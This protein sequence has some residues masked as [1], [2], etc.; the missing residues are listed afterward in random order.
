MDKTGGLDRHNEL[1]ED[2]NLGCRKKGHVNLLNSLLS[3][4]SKFIIIGINL[5]YSFL[6]K[7]NKKV[8]IYFI[9]L[10]GCSINISMM[11]CFFS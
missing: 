7:N 5:Y 3:L 11:L 8:K 1:R 4:N 10:K 6:K 9:N 2:L